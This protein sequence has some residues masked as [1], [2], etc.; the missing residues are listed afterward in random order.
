MKFKLVKSNSCSSRLELAGT[1]LSPESKDNIESIKKMMHNRT[2]TP[3]PLIELNEQEETVRDMIYKLEGKNVSLPTKPRIIESK[4]IEKIPIVSNDGSTG[5]SQMHLETKV[6]NLQHNIIESEIAEKLILE[7][8]IKSNNTVNNHISVINAAQQHNSHDIR[9]E[10]QTK[11]M[12]IVRN[13]NVDLALP[14]SLPLL[15]TAS[16]NKPIKDRENLARKASLSPLL[17]AT[18]K[19]NINENSD[20][21]EFKLTKWHSI[22]KLES[23]E[24]VKNQDKRNHANDTS[25]NNNN[26]N[27]NNNENTHNKMPP[28]ALKSSNSPS[29]N[30]T[31]KMVNWSTVGKL[32]KEY[33]ANDRRLIETKKYDEM[34]FEQFEVMGE[35]YDSLN[36]K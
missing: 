19:E 30:K 34:E 22:G 13:V 36:S 6:D 32:D 25:L 15:T 33:I 17:K 1:G 3:S 2:N 18:S 7:D 14:L 28:P 16:N 29:A 24:M 31:T 8:N 35:H 10:H 27:N 4:C 21:N 11:S 23:I 20:N 9:K 5:N 26:K 12:K